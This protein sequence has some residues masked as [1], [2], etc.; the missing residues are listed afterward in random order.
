VQ[1][2]RA[3]FASLIGARA[4]D[5]A[6]LGSTTEGVN[7]VLRGLGL[8][9]GDQV[10]TSNL[11]HSSV[12]VPCYELARQTG[13]EV[14]I[15][16]SPAN[17]TEDELAQLFEEEITTRTRLVV[18]SHISY[19]RGTRLPV[20][21]IVEAAHAAG[22]LVLLDGAQS[23]GQ[24]ALDV[25]SLGADFYA[26]P[27]HKYVL[28]PDGAGALYIR[29][30]LIE[31]VQPMAVA[32]GAA[33]AY[34]FDG[35]F[36]P[37]TASMRKFEMA[38]HSGPVLA[39]VVEAARLL[40]ETG[41]PDIEARLLALSSRLTEGLQ[42]IQGVTI[43]GPLDPALRSALVTFTVADLD[44]NETAAALWQLRRIVG[45]VVNDKRV[46]LSLAIFN[47]ESDVDAALEAI[48]Q[49]ARH[50]LPEGAMS[51]EEYKRLEAEDDD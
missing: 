26:F 11:E 1:E 42:R 29:P 38:T 41:L 22:A 30:E 51:R 2:A 50:G 36:T 32:H 23:A 6:L 48:E 21:R 5:I 34:D 3:A 33:E 31:R 35:N 39:G 19:N 7:I 15:A 4:R 37:D 10:L 44:P 16:R 27:A 20:E 46:R 24:L 25:P 12:M 40:H 47:D 45:R 8:S 9:P 14:K 49:L 17:E 18:L 28:G 43:R 13:V